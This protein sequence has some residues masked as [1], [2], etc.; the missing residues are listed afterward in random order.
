MERQSR[1]RQSWRRRPAWDPLWDG[2]RRASAPLRSAPIAVPLSGDPWDWP[3]EKRYALTQ[4][5][6]RASR[7]RCRSERTFATG[8]GVQT[9]FAQDPRAWGLPM[10]EVPV[11]GS[12]RS[13]TGSEASSASWRR[14]RHTAPWSRRGRRCGRVS[15]SGRAAS[16]RV[17]RRWDR[18]R[19]RSRTP[20]RRPGGSGRTGG[21]ATGFAPKDRV[22]PRSVCGRARGVELGQRPLVRHPQQ[23]DRRATYAATPATTTRTGPGTRRRASL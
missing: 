10:V 3:I 18:A 7:A 21:R 6:G 9:L 5:H 15:R 22:P 11:A 23:Q 16:W 1:P 2:H 12:P 17:G 20:G 13:A 19:R 14:D 8:S 4:R